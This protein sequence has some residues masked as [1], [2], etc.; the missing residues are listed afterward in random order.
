MALPDD[1]TFCVAAG[2]LRVGGVDKPG[3][4]MASFAF[5][6]A[7][8]PTMVVDTPDLGGAIFTEVEPSGSITIVIV[9][10]VGALT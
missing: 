2:G 8:G 3:T 1:A 4:I 7:I 10:P 9:E 5:A 6:F